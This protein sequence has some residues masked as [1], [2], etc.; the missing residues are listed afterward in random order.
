MWARVRRP[1]DLCCFA[2]WCTSLCRIQTVQVSCKMC[3]VA[4][5]A[6]QTA[7]S[8]ASNGLRGRAAEAQRYDL[9]LLATLQT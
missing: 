2:E 4:E 7:V 9:T 8:Q 1:S 6:M 5:I 3:G